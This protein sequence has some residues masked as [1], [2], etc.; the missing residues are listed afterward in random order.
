MAVDPRSFLI[1]NC[2][3]VR[4]AQNSETAQRKSFF[5]S[6]GKISQIEALG[7]SALGTK[8]GQGLQALSKTSNLIRTNDM[9]PTNPAVPS[10]GT[11]VLGGMDISQQDQVAVAQFNPNAVNSALD[12]ANTIADKVKVGDFNVNDIPGSFASIQHLSDLTAGIFTGGDSKNLVA[13]EL[14]GPSP[15][16]MDLLKFAPKFKYMFIVEFEF[17]DDFKNINGRLPRDPFP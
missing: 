5:N 3:S 9:D 1:K 2:G 17:A 15:F 6:L 14:C 4:N 13:Q 12:T 16:A 10:D 8:V 11:A 7:N